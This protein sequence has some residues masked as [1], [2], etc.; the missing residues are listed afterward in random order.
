M[1]RSSL[2]QVVCRRTGVFCFV[3]LFVVSNILL[4]VFCVVCF[5]CVSP[6]SC[7]LCPVSCVLCPMSCV[8]CPM[9]CVLCPMSCVLCPMSC[10]LCPMSYVLCPM[11]CVLC[12]VS[13]VLC[14][15]SCVLCP[16]FCVMCPVCPVVPVSLDGPLLIALSGFADVYYLDKH[17]TFSYCLVCEFSHKLVKYYSFIC[18]VL[19][20]CPYS[21]Q[22]DKHCAF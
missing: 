6:M 1:F 11:S 16:V 7:V 22:L 15:V 13:Y 14:S 4:L 8:L 19:F 3:C 21:R 9:S 20:V 17:Y 5:G 18:C 10:V 12:A 2:P